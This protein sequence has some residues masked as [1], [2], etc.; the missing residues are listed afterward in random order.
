MEVEK[1]KTSLSVI[2]IQYMPHQFRR[3]D[4][5]LFSFI[6]TRMVIS[7]VASSGDYIDFMVKI[8][9]IFR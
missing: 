5:G 6:F 7:S 8:E 1:T 9:N 2:H 4:M 3:R